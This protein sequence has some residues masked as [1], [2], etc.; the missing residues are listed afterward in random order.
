MGLVPYMTSS[1]RKDFERRIFEHRI[2]IQK[3]HNVPLSR[4][5]AARHHSCVAQ[6]IRLLLLNIQILKP[7]MIGRR[8]EFSESSLLVNLSR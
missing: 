2:R 8:I 7:E 1:A 6:I 3:D 4:E 5:Y